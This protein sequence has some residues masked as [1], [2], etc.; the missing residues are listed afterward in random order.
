MTLLGI[1]LSSKLHMGNACFPHHMQRSVQVSSKDI[2]QI[3][4]CKIRP[5]LDYASPVWHAGLTKEE[6]DDIENIQ[7]CEI[8]FPMKTLTNQYKNLLPFVLY[9]CQ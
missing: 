3:F 6:T 8:A 1:K 4:D 9:N 2:M 5:I 7:A